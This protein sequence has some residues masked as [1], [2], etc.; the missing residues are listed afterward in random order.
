MIIFLLI[1]TFFLSN[2]IIKI[3]DNRDSYFFKLPLLITTPPLF[4]LIYSSFLL[5]LNLL[6]NQVTDVF[7]PILNEISII[8]IKSLLCF[9]LIN[10]LLRRNL[11]PLVFPKNLKFPSISTLL[12][13]YLSFSLIE[14]IAS[15]LKFSIHLMILFGELSNISLILLLSSLIISLKINKS[16][17]RFTLISVIT[18]TFFFIFTFDK[19]F[20]IS[21]MSGI[22]L[23]LLA[24]NNLKIKL[25]IFKTNLLIMS[26]GI[27]LPVLNFIEGYFFGWN[28]ENVFNSLGEVMES[29][30]FQNYFHIFYNPN[31]S[32]KNTISIFDSLISPFKAILGMKVSFHHDLFM[33]T[34]FP[35]E[36]ANGGMKAFGLIV[37]SVLSNELPSFLFFSIATISF[38]LIIEF[39]YSRFSLFGLL[40]YSQSIE[41]VYKLTRNDL[42]SSIYFLLY[43]IIA[44]FI[45]SQTLLILDSYLPSKKNLLN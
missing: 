28:K 24:T 1:L 9:S 23:I 32:Y 4:G 3:S 33:E 6:S 2:Y 19:G 29:H 26:G 10:L 36:K 22:F 40:I 34:C 21:L 44:S 15:Q 38:I 27:L 20:S 39:L 17:Y 7:N 12:I 8:Y 5:K 13:I 35:I 18:I 37:E 16:F 11:P 45:V 31:C 14:F 42:S 43:V 41:L 25:N 30:S